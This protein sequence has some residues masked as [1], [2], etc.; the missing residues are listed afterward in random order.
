[1]SARVFE[2]SP[3]SVMNAFRFRYPDESMEINSKTIRHISFLMSTLGE[4]YTIDTISH[5][6][7]F[8]ITAQ[9]AGMDNTD[10]A[11]DLHDFVRNNMAEIYDEGHSIG[12][13]C[14]C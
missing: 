9:Y 2:Y 7:H 3:R 6:L 4:K 12:T 11:N 13:Q 14:L 10:K 1:M 8:M 5:T